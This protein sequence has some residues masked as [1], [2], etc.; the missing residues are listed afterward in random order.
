LVNNP[1]FWIIQPIRAQNELALGHLFS[2]ASGYP[3]N[4]PIPQG[5]KSVP[6]VLK[7]GFHPPAWPQNRQMGSG[8][9]FVAD[10]SLQ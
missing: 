2:L 7:L 8:G 10:E 5:S 4:L 6:G 9:A 1:K 3:A